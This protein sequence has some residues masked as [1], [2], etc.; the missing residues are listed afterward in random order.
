MAAIVA[1]SLGTLSAVASAQNLRAFGEEVPEANRYMV[2][3]G[4]KEIP[5]PAL[6]PVSPPTSPTSQPTNPVLLQS[7]QRGGRNVHTFV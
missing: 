2:G 1:V 5:N 7:H 4:M 3:W 6:E